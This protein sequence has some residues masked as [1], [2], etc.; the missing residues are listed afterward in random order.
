MLKYNVSFT[1]M[2]RNFLL[3]NY[4]YYINFLVEDLV[5]KRLQVNFLAILEDL[6]KS[7]PFLLCIIINLISTFRRLR[8][9]GS[10]LDR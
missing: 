8:D 6:Y 1:C 10:G 9:C 5:Q 3:H 2:Q 4:E 7:G